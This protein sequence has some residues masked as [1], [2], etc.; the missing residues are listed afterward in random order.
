MLLVSRIARTKVTIRVA[1]DNDN[2][3]VFKETEIFRNLNYDEETN[4]KIVKLEV[5]Y[6]NPEGTSARI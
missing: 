3:P 2:R 6:Y 1:D 5:C 4:S